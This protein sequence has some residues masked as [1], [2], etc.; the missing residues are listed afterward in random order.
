MT[1]CMQGRADAPNV[2]VTTTKIA[3]GVNI[4]PRCFV[5]FLEEPACLADFHQ[6]LGRSNR[7][8]GGLIYVAFPSSPGAKF[9]PGVLLGLL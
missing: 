4:Y 9:D 2:I 6:G 3:V 5:I 7:P 8:A 1:D